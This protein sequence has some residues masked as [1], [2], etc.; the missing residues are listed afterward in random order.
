MSNALEKVFSEIDIWSRVHHQNVVKLFEFIEAK[1]HDYLYLIIE[2][3]DLGQISS[4]DF[5]EETYTRNQS[6]VDFLSKDKEFSS[7]SQKLEH[8]AKSIFK[9]VITGVEYLH[10]FNFVHRDI[11]LDNILFSTRDSRAKLSDFSVSSELSSKE[12][13]SYN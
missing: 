9:D 2:Y 4:W 5:K 1:N 12:D 3:C 11:K 6:I 13:R 10:S 7:E 8:V